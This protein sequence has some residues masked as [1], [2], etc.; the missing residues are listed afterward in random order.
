MYLQFMANSANCQFRQAD[1]PFDRTLGSGKKSV[2]ATLYADITSPHF[3][4]FHQTAS[5]S[6]TEGKSTYRVR[7]KPSGEDTKPLVTSGYGVELALKRTDYIVIDDRPKGEEEADTKKVDDIKQASLQDEDVDDLRPLSASELKDLS[8]KAANFVLGSEDPLESLLKLTQDFPKHSGSLVAQNV[9]EEFLAEHA[10]NREILLPQGFSILWVNGAQYDPRK[11]DA[12]S[13][14]DH[15]RRERKLL[16]NFR[17][18]GLTSAE[19]VKLLSHPAIVEAY[20]QSGNQRYDWRDDTDGGNVILWLNDISKDKRYKDWPSDVFSVCSYFVSN[21]VLVAYFLQFLQRTFP[22]Q[23]P[24]VRR[25]AFNAIVPID[26]SQPQSAK[27]VVETIQSVIKRKVPLRWG[28]VPVPSTPEAEGQAKLIYHLQDAYGLISV[29]EYLDEVSINAQFCRCLLMFQAISRKDRIL[30]PHEASFKSIMEKRDLKAN[31]TKL[32]LKEVLKD[33]DL[34]E[35]LD[36]TRHYLKR[37]GALSAEAPVFVNGVPVKKDDDWLQVLSQQISLDLRTIQQGVFEEV[38]RE[39]VLIPELFLNGSSLRRNPLIIPEKDK[40][41]ILLNLPMALGDHLKAATGIPRIERSSSSKLEDSSQLLVVGDFNTRAGLQLAANAARFR[42]LNDTTDIILI[43]NPTEKST[44]YKAKKLLELYNA[45]E[46]IQQQ[47][48][49][50]ASSLELLASQDDDEVKIEKATHSWPDLSHVIENLRL[51][52]GQNG[53]LLNGRRVGPIPVDTEFLQEDFHTLSVYEEKRRNGPATT[54]ISE[55]ELQSKIKSV[56]DVAKIRSL[57]AISQVSDIPEGI[58]ETPPLV[59]SNMFYNWDDKYTSFSIGD[60]STA[61]VQLIAVLDPASEISQRWSPILKILSQLEGVFVKVFLNPKTELEE[62]PVKRFYRY[63]LQSEPAFGEDGSVLGDAAE[64][65]GVPAKALL[66][67]GMDV[68]A[69]WLVTSKESVHDLD[70]I[71]LSSLGGNGRVDAT[72]ELEYILVEGHSRDATTSGPPAGVQLVLATDEN[73]RVS[74]TIIMANLGYFQ[75][76]ANPGHYNI[77]LKE[78]PSQD[79]Y[80]IDSV[81]AL[82]YEATPGDETTDI[83]LISFQGTTL[84]PRLSRKPGREEDNVLEAEPSKVPDLVKQGANL[85]GNI[86]QKAGFKKEDKPGKLYAED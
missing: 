34:S 33:E 50:F 19:A 18:M 76:K 14:L 28:I 64:F 86:L 60:N 45:V 62:L 13:L 42:L 48:E 51:E 57:L 84:Y 43:H 79:I 8:V 23:I 41:V 5:K 52:P 7:Y 81:G 65:T 31:K 12:F 54:A 56:E 20:S 80:N 47:F 39:D 1:L 85:F 58:F 73:P 35:R 24:S 40:D 67:L 66:T 77:N 11:V 44:S 68:P 74:D 32:N 70:N 30:S 37:L 21:L 10:K 69:A 25:D 15:L 22:G 27:L 3:R 72:Y 36:N 61:A 29:I 17:K 78:G 53:V 9:S 49:N 83:T 46:D 38:I 26:F 2:I 82:G 75:F 71:K 6:A 55:L 63:V 4:K 59:R 16:N